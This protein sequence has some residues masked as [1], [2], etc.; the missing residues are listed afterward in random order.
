MN[1]EI[2]YYLK[3]LSHNQKDPASWYNL[4]HTVRRT[5]QSCDEIV[6]AIQHIIDLYP[7]SREAHFVLADLLI[8]YGHFKAGFEKLEERFKH[9]NYAYAFNLYRQ[10]LKTGA[11]KVKSSSTSGI[12]SKTWHGENL[13]GKTLLIISEGGL[14]DSIHFLRYIPLLNRYGC[15]VF[16]RLQEPLHCLF[17]HL[18][19]QIITKE[20]LIPKLDFHVFM[21]SLPYCC[22][23]D[24]SNIPPQVKIPSTL[25]PVKGRIGIVWKGSPE[26][27]SDKYRSLSLTQL[28]PLFKI[29][30]LVYVS[31]QQKVTTDEDKL[32]ESYA[33]ER[34]SLDSF[35]DTVRV[36]ERCELV[37]SVDTSMAHLA[38]SMGI[39]TWILIQY[40]A[41]WRWLIHRNDSPWYPS[42]TLFR[43]SPQNSWDEPILDLTQSLLKKV[44]ICGR[45]G[46]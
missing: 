1:S 46:G 44:E 15:K 34:P 20:L 2:E 43:Q 5:E 26:T 9:S 18:D 11:S 28:E 45:P 39:P 8:I 10:G 35:T 27:P 12:T 23:T 33:V 14:G 16:L 4:L 31:L 3:I 21:M 13:A 29:S 40:V 32:L 6:R 42:V 41:D 17:R 37:I 19:A 36:M 24:L 7:D 38:A 22:K 30:G 25:S